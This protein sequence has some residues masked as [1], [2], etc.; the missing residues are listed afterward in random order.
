M[1]LV[2]ELTYLVAITL[3]TST[4]VATLMILLAP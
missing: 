3:S 4:I 1:G 2:V